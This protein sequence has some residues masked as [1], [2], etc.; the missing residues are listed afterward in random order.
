MDLTEAERSAVRS[1]SRKDAVLAVLRAGIIDGRLGPGARL[2]Q[3]EI[4]Q[5]L[6]VS[7]MPVREALKQLETEGLVV[8]YPYRGVEV[9]RLDPEAITELF[10][11]R[12]ALERLAVSRAAVNLTAPH[13]KAMQA[14]LKKMDRSVTLGGVDDPWMRQN[15]E[16]H[17]IIN[18]ASDWP[19]L[20]ETIDQFRSNVERYVR[21]YLRTRGREQSQLEHWQLYEACARR[22]SAAAAAMIEQ[23][24]QNTADA[25]IGAIG[26]GEAAP[27]LKPSAATD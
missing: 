18:E 10:G 22:D 12:I 6:G 9:A 19:R 16:F 3:N 8:V 24:L 26:A 15:R 13:L 23:H 25:L 21:Y 5:S 20:V 2:D 14:I 4:A 17:T 27:A 1:V 11:I 7:R